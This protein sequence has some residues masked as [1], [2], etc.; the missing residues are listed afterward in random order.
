[1]SIPGAISRQHVIAAMDRLGPDSRGWPQRRLA[2]H[3]DVIHPDPAKA[4]RMPP[5][6][7]LSHAALIA[8]GRELMP[9]EFGGG[10]ETNGYLKRLGFRVIDRRRV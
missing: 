8:T 2:K 5:K 10:I 7:V 3:Y 1:M 4:W 6:L 9:L